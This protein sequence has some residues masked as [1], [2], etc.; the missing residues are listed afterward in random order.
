MATAARSPANLRHP[1]WR[2][3]QSPRLGV[4]GR[5]HAL[6]N[7]PSTRPSWRWP[8]ASTGPARGQRLRAQLA[9]LRKLSARPSSIARSRRCAWRR[10]APADE[11]LARIHGARGFGREPRRRDRR[12]LAAA[13]PVRASP[14]NAGAP[15]K[16]LDPVFGPRF[17][18]LAGAAFRHGSPS[19]ASACS[20]VRPDA[21]HLAAPCANA[22][23][24]SPR[25]RACAT[26][27]GPCRSPFAG[28]CN[29]ALGLRITAAVG[30]N[31]PRSVACCSAGA[32]DRRRARPW[33]GQRLDRLG[34]RGLTGC[35]RLSSASAAQR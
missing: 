9:Y 27:P 1:R 32:R 29:I 23:P 25:L 10:I 8:R 22:R 3:W 34:E 12:P 5:G 15:V 14:H 20:A 13:P 28:R 30:W 31:S 16:L 17:W 4:R 2:R 18:H 24:R 19:C 35:P 26:A 21:C 6:I 33:I 7:W 11:A